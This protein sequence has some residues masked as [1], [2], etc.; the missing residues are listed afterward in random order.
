MEAIFKFVMAFLAKKSG[1]ILRAND[2]IVRDSVEQITQT[3]KNMGL[4]VSK[5]KSTKEVEKYLNIHQSWLM[6]QK[7]KEVIGKEADILPFQY[8]KTFKQEID[9][10]S[11]K[12]EVVEKHPLQD[13]KDRVEPGSIFDDWAKKNTSG[14]RRVIR[15]FDITDE[16]LNFVNTG[17]INYKQMEKLL[18]QKLKGTE[19]W[20]WTFL[21]LHPLKKLKNF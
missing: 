19:T 2:P 16:H 15:S 10:M 17:K 5:I 14:A 3:L 1:K 4:D 11:K 12:G 20:V 9:E 21:K 7:P 8:K 6:K 13:I 18:G